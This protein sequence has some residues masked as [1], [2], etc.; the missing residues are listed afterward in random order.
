MLNS[1]RNA[2]SYCGTLVGP[3]C[4]STRSQGSV[5]LPVRVQWY[6]LDAVL[7]FVDEQKWDYLAACKTLAIKQESPQACIR[8]NFH[9]SFIIRLSIVRPLRQG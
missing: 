8:M 1:V 6:A 5:A 2:G 7:R 4:V 9:A 3:Q